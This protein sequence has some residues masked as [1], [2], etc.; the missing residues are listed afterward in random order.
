MRS[1]TSLRRAAEAGL[2]HPSIVEPIA[3]G[4]EGTVAYRAEEYVAA[5]SLDVAMRHYAPAAIDKVLPFI[6]QLAG[7]IDFA[8]AAGV[9]HGALHPRDIFVTPD[10]AR[11]TGFRR[12][13]RARARRP[14]RAGAPARTARPSASPGSPGAPP[15]DV[16]SLA[17]IAFELLTGRRPSGIGDQIGSL[18]GASVG[19]QA[20]ALHAVLA[21][22]MSESADDRF[23]NA[24]AFASALEAAARPGAL[25]PEF[26][27]SRPA[28]VAPL[29]STPPAIDDDVGEDSRAD[30]DER[31]DAAVESALG[32]AGVDIDD[33]GAAAI[34]DDDLN[35]DD[36]MR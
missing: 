22:A 4:V 8:R 21:R 19:D 16:F 34:D 14:A 5:E 30:E 12:R 29:A 28:A 20:D 23:S 3:A 31:H 10:E 36:R 15:A 7:A 11:A 1:P 9:G 35:A 18:A 25:V 26:A 6:T 2:F 17:A 24:L 13:R 33:P 32:V 27:P